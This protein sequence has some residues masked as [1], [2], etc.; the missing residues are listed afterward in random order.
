MRV[1]GWC[2]PRLMG[3]IIRTAYDPASRAMLERRGGADNDLGGGDEGLPSGVDL[4]AA[5]PMHAENHWGYYRSDSAV[6][7]CW[8]IAQWPRRE[9]EAGF[10]MPLLLSSTCRRA[11]SWVM[12]PVPVDKARRTVDRK[13]GNASSEQKLRDKI[14]RRTSRLHQAE[15]DHLD[16]REIEIAA[17]YGTVRMIG[18][19]AT[20]ADDLEQLDFQTAEIERLAHQSEIEI[21]RLWGEHD[22]AFAMTALPLARGLR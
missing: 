18:F 3:F 20:S 2:P 22:Q 16:R 8:W 1:E 4:S 21:T 17:G 14:G 19:I 10:L 7:R 9:V 15:E 13:L 6:H 11:V 12:E 5:G